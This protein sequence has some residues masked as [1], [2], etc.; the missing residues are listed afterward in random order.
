MRFYVDVDRDRD[1]S[2]MLLLILLSSSSFDSHR[3]GCLNAANRSPCKHTHLICPTLVQSRSACGYSWIWM[4]W[5]VAGI[6]FVSECVNFSFVWLESSSRLTRW[7]FDPI[8]V[9]LLCW[10]DRPFTLRIKQLSLPKTQC[11]CCVSRAYW[12]FKKLHPKKYNFP[13]SNPQNVSCQSIK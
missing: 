10:E 2:L 9:H 12:I 5:N 1:F 6:V 3:Y 13:N 11:R 4:F 8:A 7:P